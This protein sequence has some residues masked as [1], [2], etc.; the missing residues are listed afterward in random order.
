MKT[1]NR[2]RAGENE[3]KVK[4]RLQQLGLQLNG[5][6]RF[7]QDDVEISVDESFTYDKRDYYVEIDS[8]NMAK[9]LAGQYMLLNELIPR[10]SSPPFFLVVHMYNGYNP[11]RTLKNLRLLNRNL[12]GGTGIEFGAMHFD[13]FEDIGHDAGALLA[14]VR[15]V[16]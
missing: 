1:N 10:L 4:S 12:Y 6:R 11:E 8:S 3:A 2:G 5:K 7:V 14:R 15:P 13:E 16:Q 9:L